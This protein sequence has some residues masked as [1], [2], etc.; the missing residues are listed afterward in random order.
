M[1]GRRD[2][3]EQHY[4]NALE[5]H[6][7]MEAPYWIARTQLDLADLLLSTDHDQAVALAAAAAARAATYGYEALATRAGQLN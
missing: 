3:A 4:R 7:G 5:I 6:E 2:E 1:L